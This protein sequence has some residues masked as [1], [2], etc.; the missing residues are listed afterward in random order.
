M[1][2]HVAING[3]DTFGSH[4]LLKYMGSRAYKNGVA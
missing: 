4:L 2:V 3:I 1:H